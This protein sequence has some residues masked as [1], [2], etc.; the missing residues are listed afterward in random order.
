MTSK[1][2]NPALAGPTKK[3][4]FSDEAIH[5]F[6]GFYHVLLKVRRRLLAEGYMIKNGKKVRRSGNFRKEVYNQKTI[7]P[8]HYDIKKPNAQ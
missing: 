1:S 4:L 6:V 8:E 2:P 3:Y 7:K 5:N